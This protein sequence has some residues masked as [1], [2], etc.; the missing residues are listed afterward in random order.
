MDDIS[1]Y[2]SK[3]NI[4]DLSKNKTIDKEAQN[5]LTTVNTEV[6]NIKNE[7]VNIFNNEKAVIPMGFGERDI[8]MESPP[9]FDDIFNI[10]FL[11]QMMKLNFGHTAV[12]SAISYKKEVHDIFKLN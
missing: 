2:I 11:R 10:M 12:F 5:I 9:L 8:V 4:F 1:I 6:Q 3:V 7:I